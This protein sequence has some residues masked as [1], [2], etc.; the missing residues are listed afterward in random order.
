M[1]KLLLI[2]DD[3]MYAHTVIDAISSYGF[4]ISWANSID[5][6][7]TQI[8][9]ENFDIFIM[10]I[11]LGSGSG[12]EFLREL[13]ISGHD[14]PTLFLTS[15][16]SS[17]TAVE[18]FKIGCD[19]YVRKNCA[20]DEIIERIR[21]S[22]KKNYPKND[23]LITL[24][25]GYVYNGLSRELQKDNVSIEI[26]LKELLLLELFIKRQGITLSHDEIAAALWA[27]SENSSFASLRVYINSIKKLL[28]KDTIH[29]AKG[30]GYKFVI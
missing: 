12:I 11:N 28:G 6:A 20:M 8:Y 18:C 14:K 10:D 25:N 5:E 3:K 21:L 7:I 22:I 15:D 27:P 26:A 29:N 16:I 4:E 30:I 19:D 24:P 2:E 9:L 17:A 1:H 23:N 13:K